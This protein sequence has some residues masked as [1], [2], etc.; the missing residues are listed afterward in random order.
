MLMTSWSFKEYRSLQRVGPSPGQLFCC[1]GSLLKTRRS[2]PTNKRAA[3]LGPRCERGAGFPQIL[4]ELK[5]PRIPSQLPDL[6]PTACCFKYQALENPAS[7]W[8]GDIDLE[9]GG[10]LLSVHSE[11]RDETRSVV[12]SP[13]TTHRALEPLN[14]GTPFPSCLLGHSLTSPACSMQ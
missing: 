3:I 1:N 9:M 8:A 5:P 14:P 6:G 7:Y 12:W 4:G 11:V 10:E 2:F 13:T